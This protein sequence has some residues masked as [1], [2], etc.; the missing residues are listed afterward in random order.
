[1]RPCRIIFRRTILNLTHGYLISREV[2][3]YCDD[4]LLACLLDKVT[5]RILLWKFER[6]PPCQVTEFD[7]K[8]YGGKTDEDRQEKC[9]FVEECQ[10]QRRKSVSVPIMFLIYDTDK[11]ED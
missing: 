2:H 4:C 8:L 9:F 1:M 3:P 10:V 7:G 5:F 6:Y 11:V